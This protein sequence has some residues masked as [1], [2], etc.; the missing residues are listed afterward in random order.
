MSPKPSGCR[1]A[2]LAACV[3]IP[4]SMP[5]LTRRPTPLLTHPYPTPYPTT[6]APSDV[7][8]GKIC[9]KV[10][11]DTDNDND[12]DVGSEAPTS[13][14]SFS[15]RPGYVSVNNSRVGGC[16]S[17]RLYG[18]PVVIVPDFDDADRDTK[19]GRHLSVRR[20]L[21]LYGMDKTVVPKIN[22]LTTDWPVCLIS[23]Y[24]LSPLKAFPSPQFLNRQDPD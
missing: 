12:G 9:G 20:F 13:Q 24:I 2:E 5:L 22:S 8:L 11:E 7:P 18:A 16:L 3:L 23:L 14:P 1:D 21:Q 4:T 6:P 17:R 15:P 19:F 10:M